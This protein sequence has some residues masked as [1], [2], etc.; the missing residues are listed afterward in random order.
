M[1]INIIENLLLTKLKKEYVNFLLDEIK[2][3]KTIT[4]DELNKKLKDKY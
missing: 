4:L 2:K 1:Q 3:N